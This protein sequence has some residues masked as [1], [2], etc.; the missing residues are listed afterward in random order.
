MEISEVRVEIFGPSE[1]GNFGRFVR[2]RRKFEVEIMKNGVKS[3]KFFAC[4]AIFDENFQ[5]VI[6]LGGKIAPKARKK[7]KVE[8]FGLISA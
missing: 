4:G 8:I 7:I 6:V 3:G 1:G 2:H 5:N